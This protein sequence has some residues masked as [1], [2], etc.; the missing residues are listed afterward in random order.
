MMIPTH[1]HVIVVGGGVTGIAAAYHLT[2]N[3]IPF[4]LLEASGDVGG[5]WHTQRWHG[6]RCDSDIVKY[7]FSF[8]PL[9]CNEVVVDRARLQRYLRDVVRRHGI[10]RRILL[11]T[12]VRSADFSRATG[13][14]TVRTTRS[15]YTARF[16][17]NGNGYFAETPH[18]PTFEGAADF[19]GE[20]VHTAHLDGGRTFRDENVVLLGSGAT[21]VSCAPSLAA[22]SRS[23]TLLQRS[24]SYVYEM[25]NRASV[26]VRLALALQRLG[27]RFALTITR[28][29]LQVRDDCAFVAL[30]RWPAFG[31][32]L[33]RHRWTAAVGEAETL[34]HFTPR[35]DPWQ[36]R[37][38]VSIGFA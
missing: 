23:L 17:Y 22:V 15:V 11:N 12:R 30:R 16:L 3:R 10:E 2:A 29:L 28:H 8:A 20:I 7:A 38:C 36:Q 5:V 32:R 24:P 26:S 6:A 34:A 27:V 13:R 1:V 9:P 21:A 4:L 31:R 37:I 14:W 19:E 35:Y 33:F 18:I 25:D